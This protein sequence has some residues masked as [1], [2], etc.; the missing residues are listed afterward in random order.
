MN[1]YHLRLASC[2]SYLLLALAVAS[3]F[4]CKERVAVQ[5]EPLPSARVPETI[6][7]AFQNATPPARE[8]ASE[9]L[10]ALR[11]GDDV[12]AFTDLNQ[13]SARPELTPEQRQAATRSLMSLHER[14]RTA[15]NS[16]NRE[17]EKLLEQ[18]RASK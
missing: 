15:A 2:M 7:T 10:D 12:A 14:L 6:E 13:L 8:V 9:A 4:G 3:Q 18:Y 17:A 11:S 5:V 1:F 16:G